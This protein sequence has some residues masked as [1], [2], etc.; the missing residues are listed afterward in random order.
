MVELQGVNIAVAPITPRG[1]NNSDVDFKELPISE[2]QSRYKIQPKDGA[3]HTVCFLR[4]KEDAWFA[5]NVRVVKPD[6]WLLS[7][8][9]ANAILMEVIVDR[10]SLAQK[11]LLM[12]D[13]MRARKT[14]KIARFVHGESKTQQLSRARF[15]QRN[16]R[17]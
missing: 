11:T 3:K 8:D 14:F 1:S 16:N 13:D 10:G 6:E 9:K 15:E 12:K 2:S 5:V 7:N 17:T 4:V